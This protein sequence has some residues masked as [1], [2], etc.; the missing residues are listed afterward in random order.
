MS[1]IVSIDPQGDLVVAIGKDAAQILARVSS[2]VTKL[3][4]PVFAVMLGPLFKEGQTTHDM[5]NPLKLPDDDPTSMLNLCHLIHYRIDQVDNKRDDWLQ[6]LIVLCDKYKCMSSLLQ[7]YIYCHMHQSAHLPAG[8]R[9]VIYALIDH[10]KQ[11]HSAAEQIVRLP[12]EKAK[13]KFHKELLQLTPEFMLCEL[14]Y[15]LICLSLTIVATM[16]EYRQEARLAYQDKIHDLTIGIFCSTGSQEE[17]GYTDYALC[18]GLQ[19]RF[20]MLY[21]SLINDK[22]LSRKKLMDYYLPDMAE[23][24]LEDLC[25]RS[26]DVDEHTCPVEYGTCCATCDLSVKTLVREAVRDLGWGTSEHC[27]VCLK[28]FQAGVFKFRHDC[29]W[30]KKSDAE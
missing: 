16:R 7:G 28:C 10:E 5:A 18:A 19:R 1:A 4:S 9:M 23:T 29:A 22:I 24:L 13:S 12:E 2:T 17:E 14:P 21:A 26:R 15:K 11:F 20:A 30:H 25:Q 8:D 6:R 3:A 27:R